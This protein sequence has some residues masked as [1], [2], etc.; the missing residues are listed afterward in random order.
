[1]LRDRD[2]ELATLEQATAAKT[3]QLRKRDMALSG[4]KV[5][6][7][8]QAEHATH[9]QAAVSELQARATAAEQA[10]AQQVR[11]LRAEQAATLEAA[12]DSAARQLAACR[13]AELQ[14]QHAHQAQV[15]AEL[16]RQHAQHVADMQA[17]RQQHEATLQEQF[18]LAEQAQAAHAEAQRARSMATTQLQALQEDLA[19]LTDRCASAEA[20]ARSQSSE[21]HTLQVQLAA[22]EAQHAWITEQRTQA[23]SLALAQIQ[24][25]LQ[26]ARERAQQAE[27]ALASATE[28]WLAQRT[29]LLHDATVART[30]LVQVQRTSEQTNTAL[31]EFRSQSDDQLRALQADLALA[32]TENAGL[33]DQ[34]RCHFTFL[35]VLASNFM[36]H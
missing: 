2:T 35:I 5:Q 14:Q 11:V 22:V 9:L 15:S 18:F 34:V 4:L 21:L 36:F 33:R 12:A 16:Q 25:D 7:A 32:R 20:H 27:A 30:E 19:T 26:A 10:H 29:T 6:L 17:Q 1:L 31:E 28:T 3:R 23:H 8:E 13:A 24:S